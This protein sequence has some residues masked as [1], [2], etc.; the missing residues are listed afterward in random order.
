M[1]YKNFKKI[2][3][4]TLLLLFTINILGINAK[5]SGININARCAVAIDA[6]SKTVLYDKNAHM[7]VPMAST[8][9]IMT[10]LVAIKHGNLDKK[11]EI[12]E[13]AA[14]IHGSTVGY[15]EG[16][17][18]TLKELLYGLMLRSGND[19]AIA[20]AEGVGGSVDEFLKLMNEYASQIGVYDTH[21]ESPHGLDSENHYSTSYDLAVI[22]A[23]ARENELFNDIVKSKD[24]DGEVQKF[25]RS[26]HNINK[27]LWQ[28]PN[29]N[30]VKTG[31]T[32][33]AGKCLVTSVD[34]HGNNIIIVVLNSPTRWNETKK[35]NDYVE[36]NYEFK[37]FYSKGEVVGEA[38]V[39]KKKIKLA[40]DADIIIPIKIGA[41]YEAK[42]NKPNYKIDPPIYKGSDLGSI[43]IYADGSKIYSNYL[44]ACSTVEKHNIIKR[45]FHK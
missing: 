12:S 41:N 45:L 8:T 35:I 31:Y 20:I 15:K 24:V 42:V 26:Y 4:I 9:K 34:I 32:G 43:N 36:K 40:V 5:A 29:A 2:I 33:Q 22:T 21:F 11:I 38:L 14:N 37:K 3:Y 10:A 7:L 18:I 39:G 13:K 19:A 17:M 16:E 1:K 28:L 27:I 30:G 44:K 25:T 6:K 23:K